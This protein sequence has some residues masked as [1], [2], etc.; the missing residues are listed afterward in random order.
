[1]STAPALSSSH[2]Y[3]KLL[4]LHFHRFVNRAVANMLESKVKDIGRRAPMS[5]SV[6]LLSR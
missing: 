6:P 4:L 5:A 1:M 3:L 2:R